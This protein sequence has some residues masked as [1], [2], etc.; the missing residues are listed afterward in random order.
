[1]RIAYLINQYPKASHSFIRREMAELERQG[2]PVQRIALRR[3]GE[4]LADPDDRQDTTRT[5]YVLD[6]WKTAPALAAA[7]AAM[8]L[9]HPL[10][11]AR[12]AWL[13]WR[14]GW[15]AQRPLPWQL[16]YL[17]EACRVAQLVRSGQASHLHA[18][19]GTNATQVAMLASVL[20][21]LPYSFTVHGPEEFD[22]PAAL[23]LCEKIQHASFV[24]AVC[25]YGGSQLYRCLPHSEWSKVRV[26][27]CGL[28]AG[29]AAA[30][31]D[32]GIEAL[33]PMPRLICVGRLCAQKG[34]LLL[35]E[36]LH[37]LRQLGKPAQLV[38][39]GDGELRPSI[40]ALVARLQLQN[41]VS[42]TGWL[43]GAEVQ[44]HIRAAHAFV[45]PS[46]AEG[47]PVALM[48]AMALQR[49]VLS[50]YIAGIPEL[51][52]PGE[53]G[54]LVPAGDLD[55]LVRALA[56]VLATPPQMLARM[57]H[58]GSQLIRQRHSLE[59]SVAQLAAC[60]ADRSHP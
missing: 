13:A 40:E 39:A 33:Q 45:L 27:R 55:A 50:T 8:L 21:G 36:A 28:P 29:F 54:W 52:C 20:S 60:F 56:A 19:F 43:S 26:L 18:H 6:G 58:N 42:I 38:L 9:R 5:A 49:P 34:Q 37:R 41:Q 30:S 14:T 7:A 44:Q 4:A 48:E 2:H 35:V 59:Q 51:V 16:A 17:A 32:V 47:L 22:Q 24:V 31:S 3:S 1:M 12:A 23:R 57:G 15:R 11:L 25:H 10:R 46:F 53:N